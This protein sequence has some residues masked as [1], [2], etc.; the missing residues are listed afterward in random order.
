MTAKARTGDI[1]KKLNKINGSIQKKP[2]IPKLIV[3]V[4]AAI[5]KVTERYRPGF[6]VLLVR[7]A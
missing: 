6:V 3:A 5:G 1:M 7:H 4:A 2:F